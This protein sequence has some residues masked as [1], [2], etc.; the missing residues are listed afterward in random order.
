MKPLFR[1]GIVDKGRHY[2]MIRC[3]RQFRRSE[4]VAILQRWVRSVREQESHRRFVAALRCSMKSCISTARHNIRL[5][6]ST[7]EQSCH[8]VLI[9]GNGGYKRTASGTVKSVRIDALVKKG[10]SAK[11]VTL[12]RELNKDIVRRRRQSENSRCQPLPNTVRNNGTDKYYA[13][14]C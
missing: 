14:S 13:N 12:C 4:S 3:P 8:L 2:F 6:P 1:Q 7:K 10:L 5:R 11:H 9:A